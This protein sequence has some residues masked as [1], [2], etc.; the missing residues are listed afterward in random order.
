MFGVGAEIKLKYKAYL[1]EQEI[2]TER[3]QDRL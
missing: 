1:G 3:K 2:K